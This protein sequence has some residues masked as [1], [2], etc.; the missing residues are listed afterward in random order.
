MSIQVRLSAE[1]HILNALS[2]VPHKR[3]DTVIDRSKR[4]FDAIRPILDELR[5]ERREAG[6]E[7]AARM[8]EEQ[9]QEQLAAQLRKLAA[10]EPRPVAKMESH[11]SY[12]EWEAMHF[13]IQLA[14]SAKPEEPLRR[15]LE[16]CEQ[17]IGGYLAL[18][19]KRL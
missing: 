16:Q 5:K 18:N 3:A 8:A 15:R 7:E 6:L 19:G 4:E 10:D 13:A 17:R 9:K 12:P 14:L 1:E 2:R 11:F